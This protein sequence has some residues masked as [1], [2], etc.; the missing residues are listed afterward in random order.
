MKQ[1]SFTAE[2]CGA[3]LPERA[4]V[5]AGLCSS[6]HITFHN[7]SLLDLALHHRSFCHEKQHDAGNNERLEFLGDAVLGMATASYLYTAMADRPEGDLAKIKSIVVSEMTLA[8]IALAAGIDRCLRLGNGEER[9]GGRQKKAILADALEAIIGAYYLDAGYAQAEAFVLSIIIPDIEKVLQN[10]HQKNYK[11]LLQELYQKQSKACPVYTTEK[12]SGPDHDMTFW[13]SVTVGTHTY[14]PAKGKN[15]KEAEQAA[16]HI[17]YQ[18]LC[19]Q[20]C[21]PPE[22]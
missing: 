18:A 2:P 17:A 3:L 8:P 9:S 22:H 21:L 6:L 15:K 12:Q 19:A 16:A 7:V 14:G 11:T 10:K 13:V 1:K 5:L 4:A 20:L